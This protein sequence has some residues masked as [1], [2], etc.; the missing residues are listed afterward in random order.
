MV[1]VPPVLALEAL[2]GA[3]LDHDVE[4]AVRAAAQAGLAFAVH[5][6]P[7]SG[8]D[9]GGD[10]HLNGAMDADLADAVAFGALVGDLLSGAVADGAF[11]HHG[12]EAL[13]DA[14]LSA[15]FAAVAAFRLRAFGASGAAACGA[16]AG[17]IELDLLRDAL[18]RLVQRDAEVVAQV[19]AVLR[20]VRIASASAEERLEAAASSATAEELVED[21]EGVAGE[22]AAARS[23]AVRGVLA[24]LV[25]EL[26]FFLVSEYLVG[27]GNLFELLLGLL[28]AGVLVR[29]VFHRQAPVCLFDGLLVGVGG[30]LQ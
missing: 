1:T 3:D 24:V 20:A 29:V 16:E 22:S 30:D 15:P 6:H 4:V 5:A 11:V 26:A 10:V 2:V 8:V 9:A 13:G 18:E 14:D 28:G 25:V 21:V 7:V 19:R 12:E 27:V 23:A 17:T